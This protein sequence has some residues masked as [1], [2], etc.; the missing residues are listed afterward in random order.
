[1]TNSLLPNLWGDDKG[2]HDIFSS[3]HKEIDRVFDDFTR[4]GK[5]PFSAAANG[6]GEITPHIDVSETDGEVEVSAELPGVEE[7]EI[8][9]SL[10]DDILTIKAEKKS[11]TEK[12]EKEYRLIE[13]TYGTFQRSMRL[14][15]P[16]VADKVKAEFKNGVLT[17]KLPKSP[18]VQE[19]TQKIAVKAV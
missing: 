16:V 5:W 13:R 11:E 3:L 15:C 6:E 8:D 4:G 18:D 17:I 19:K 2:R 14:P 1:M 7:K 10:T 9:V 12:S